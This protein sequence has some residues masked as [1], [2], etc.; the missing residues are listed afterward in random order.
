MVIRP[1]CVPPSLSPVSDTG[2]TRLPT[3]PGVAIS[4]RSGC[5]VTLS[6]R[7]SQSGRAAFRATESAR[8]VAPWTR[9]L[10]RQLDVRATR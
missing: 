7:V 4:S 5:R 8:G 3:P 9:S 2:V 6:L 10:S 1:A